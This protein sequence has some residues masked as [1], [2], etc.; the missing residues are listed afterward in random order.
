MKK[1]LFILS[2][3]ISVASFAQTKVTAPLNKN[4]NADTTYSTHIDSLGKGGYIPF[5]LKSNMLL[6]PFAQRTVGQLVYGSDVDSFYYFKGGINN[7]NLFGFKLGGSVV[8]SITLNTSGLIHNSP[9]TFTNSSGTW[10]GTQTLVTT[11]ANHSI[12]VS[13]ITG[14]T[15]IW[16]TNLDSNYVSALHSSLWY[17]GINDAKYGT[18]TQQNLN[19]TAI[20][21]KLDSVKRKVASDSVFWYANG[22]KTFAFRDSTGGGLPALQSSH[23]FMGNNS[24]IAKD[25]TFT[26]DYNTIPETSIYFPAQAIAAS[27]SVANYL[28]ASVDSIQYY[29]STSPISG[30]T[31][32]YGGW[33]APA[34]SG[35]SIQVNAPFG[36]IIGD[37]QAQGNGEL[38]NGVQLRGRL[39]NY[40]GNFIYNYPD[41]SGQLSYEFRRL[42]NMRWYNNGIGGQTSTL[43][44]RRF[45]RDVLGIVSS[46][47]GDAIGPRTMYAKASIVVIIAGI[48]DPFNGVTYQQTEDNLRYMAAVCQTYGVMCI[49]CNIPGDFNGNSAMHTTINQVNNW[50]KNGALDQYGAVIFNYHDWAGLASYGFDNTHK[51]AFIYDDVHPTRLGYQNLANTVFAQTNMPV[52]SSLIINTSLSPSIPIANYNR[53]TAITI[54]GSAYS[55]PNVGVDT[56]PITTYVTDTAWIK[57]TGSTNVVGTSTQTGFSS[58]T[59]VLK[60]NPNNN[61]TYTKKT[62]NN[63]S[64]KFNFTGSFLNLQVPDFTN[65]DQ[66]SIKESDGV[67]E[68]LYFNGGNVDDPFMVINGKSTRTRFS[69]VGGN[70]CQLSVYGPGGIA[71]NGPIQT[72]SGKSSF[73]NFQIGSN[74]HATNSGQGLGYIAPTMWLETGTG[75]SQDGDQFNLSQSFT[76]SPPTTLSNSLFSVLRLNTGWGQTKN[77]DTLFTSFLDPK[78][79]SP[80]NQAA[81]I[82][83]GYGFRPQLTNLGTNRLVSNWSTDG[84]QLLNTIS[85]KTGIG[86]FNPIGSA[87]LDV[88]STKQGFIAPR[89]TTAQRDSIGYISAIT[90]TAG[91]TGFTTY[92]TIAITGGTGTGARAAVS[93]A[94]ATSA[95]PGLTLLDNGVGYKTSSPVTVT[96]TGGGGTGATATATVHGADSGL[97]IFNTDVNLLQMYDG[98][99]WT[100]FA[101][102]LKASATLSFGATLAQTSTDLTVAV[103]GA[104][105]GD[106]VIIGSPTNPINSSWSAFVSATDVVTIRFSNYSSGSITPT[107]S[108]VFNVKVFKD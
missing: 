70:Y 92:P 62:N 50:L 20:T 35:D 107:A 65:G 37:S 52:L 103:T 54:N 87:K 76:S 102:I 15:P 91:G 84:D 73:N 96:I 7:G 8:N 81:G 36:V 80:T 72:T 28:P 11:L 22:V 44:R 19:T 63:G 83:G 39:A 21:L 108:S 43:I 77:T 90:L 66:I 30:S 29:Y 3:F 64:S 9:T 97:V 95:L 78:F 32:D 82:F 48:N 53:P 49:I 51:N 86:T 1:I 24:S 23:I 101:K 88:T 58:L 79:N 59:W 17:Q 41:S 40:T 33:I 61:I 13:G 42:T 104:S 18:L 12:L 99:R 31:T 100:S 34:V 10:S 56:L 67:T 25:T 57:I 93:P 69:T 2:L 105:V 89:M 16:A 26:N 45:L 55:L 106:A 68:T 47:S 75:G 27:T 6:L 94:L 74:A 46:N 98:N 5:S 38:V 60:N 85:G 14:T 71:A 4:S